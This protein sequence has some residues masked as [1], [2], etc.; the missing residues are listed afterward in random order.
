MAINITG[1]L[2]PDGDYALAYAQ[3]IIHSDGRTIEEVINSMDD[4]NTTLILG[5]TFELCDAVSEVVTGGTF[6]QTETFKITDA[7]A[8]IIIGG[9]F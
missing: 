8:E 7:A 1:T 5:G 9:T 3:D 6:S 2:V 4:T